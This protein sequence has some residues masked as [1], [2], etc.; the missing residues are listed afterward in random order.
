LPTLQRTTVV[1]GA[2]IGQEAEIWD[3][4]GTTDH[5]KLYGGGI[6]Q[7]I[8]V[9]ERRRCIH[10]CDGLAALRNVA[11]IIHALPRARNDLR[12]SAVSN[13]ADDGHDD[14]V[15]GRARRR[16]TVVRPCGGIETPG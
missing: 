5:G 4:A 7:T 11:A 3:V 16:G 15:A 8:A 10:D 14:A 1:T 13:G 12:T 2:G 9:E 6:A